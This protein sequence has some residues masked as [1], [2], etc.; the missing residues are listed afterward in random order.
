MGSLILVALASIC[1]ACMDVTSFHWNESIFLN[2][3]D[4][5]IRNFFCT[6]QS[7]RL[8]YVD[9]DPTKGRRKILG[10][11]NLH[12]AFTDSWHL[13]KSI[14]IVLMCLAIVAYEP[15][16]NWWVD[17]IIL[18]TTWNLTFSLFYNKIFKSN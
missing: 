2:I 7:W 1:N 16:I 9:G 5:D 14:M 4:R 11:F 17:L 12:P 6:P 3:K 15:L 13:C 18:G 10:M 8:K